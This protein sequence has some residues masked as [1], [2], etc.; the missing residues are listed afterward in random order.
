MEHQPKMSQALVGL[1][2]Q[3]SSNQHQ[4]CTEPNGGICHG[5]VY[6]P[7]RGHSLRKETEEVGGQDSEMVPERQGHDSWGPINK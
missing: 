2:P 1:I 5:E 4:W 6:Q 3:Q 7:S